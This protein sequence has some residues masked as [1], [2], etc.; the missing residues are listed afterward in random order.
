[1]DLAELTSW[2]ERLLAPLETLEML[3]EADAAFENKI[4]Y[5]N[6]AALATMQRLHRGL[7]IALRGADVR[8]AFGHSIH[9]FHKDPQRI[10]NILRDL[11]SGKMAMHATEMSI[12]E[13]HFSLR[14]SPIHDHQGKVIAFHASWRDITQAR[15]AQDIAGRTRVIVD[16]MENTASSV[17]RAM[18]AAQSAITQIAS[19]IDE[20]AKIIEDLQQQA[21]GI[22][23]LVET[24]RAISSQTNLLALNAAIEAARAG[25]AGRGFAVVADEVRNLA[26]NVQSATADVEVNTH[27][28]ETQAQSIARSGQAS[29]TEMAQVI[30]MTQDLERNI[31][32]LQLSAS[33]ALLDGVQDDHRLFIEKYTH[34]ATKGASSCHPDDVP[35]HHQC[36]LGKWYDSRGKEEFGHL[37]SFRELDPVHAKVHDTAKR[38]LK[39]AQAGLSD[40]VMTLTG[41]LYELQGQVVT[42]LQALS[43]AISSEN[44]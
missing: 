21:H 39:A 5:M 30:Q 25:E 2:A 36:R 43:S 7:N 32:V 19:S 37:A 27:A 28:I 44:Q 24:I 17:G 8:T 38:L 23:R 33:R 6:N 16:E 10:K 20:N 12:G 11:L 40:D 26:R 34:E 35:D 3:A 31:H 41:D 18:R 42:K 13:I 15:H 4:F 14:F 9:Q 22:N 29:A 1:M